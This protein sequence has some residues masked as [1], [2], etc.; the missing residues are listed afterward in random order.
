MPV[1]IYPSAA[2]IKRNGVFQNLPAFVSE[3]DDNA[4]Q[5]MIA[6][7]ESSN[8][9]QYKHEIGEYFRLNDVLY[10]TTAHISVGDNIVVGTNCK[11]AVLANKVSLLGLTVNGSVVSIPFVMTGNGYMGRSNNL[12]YLRYINGASTGDNM[13]MVIN[14]LSSY[15]L[16]VGDEITIKVG[17]DTGFVYCVG[18]SNAP[19]TGNM[20]LMS[21]VEFPSE[22]A[23]QTITFTIPENTVAIAISNKRY[24][25]A[26]PEI[27]KTKIGI[28]EKIE[29]LTTTVENLTEEVDNISDDVESMSANVDQLDTTVNGTKTQIQFVQT[30]SGYIPG[31]TGH[32]MINYTPDGTGNNQMMVINDLSLYGLAVGDIM[33]V[34]VGWASGYINAVAFS[35][36]EITGTN[37]VIDVVKYVGE[38][39]PQTLEF[40][41]PEG[42]VGIAIFNRKTAYTNPTIYKVMTKSLNSKIVEVTENVEAISDTVDEISTKVNDIAY[43]SCVRKPMQFSEKSILFFGDSITYGYIAASGET[44]THQATNQYPKVFSEGVGATYTNNGVSGA[45]LVENYEDY[46]SIFTRIKETTLNTDYIFI[47]GGVN[48]WQTGVDAAALETGVENICDYLDANYTGEVIF[49]TPIN[50]AG[51][52]PSVTPT[53]TLQNVRNIITRVALKHGYSVVQGW[54][55]P[56][57]TENDDSSYISLMFQDRLHPTELG[58]SMF[59]QALRNAVC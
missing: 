32:E 27:T 54:E 13:V 14:D 50:E 8:V 20:A 28:A 36:S 31:E 22:D 24:S 25:L 4:A 16:S 44:P 52:V 46:Y 7:A 48:D 10:E 35:A 29:A 45:V 34:T 38:G 1:E 51:R 39:N 58:Y 53:Q 19:I 9:A 47:A 11:V 40:T 42:T 55:F 49:I 6:I 2:K 30:G 43:N 33:Q 56:F 41:I 5:Q 12:P 15:G 17:W 21:A 18:F 37:A 59:A 23:V 26:N 57:P 3:S